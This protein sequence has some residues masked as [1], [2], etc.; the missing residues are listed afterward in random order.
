MKICIIG[1]EEPVYF[2]PFLRSIIEARPKDII[3]VVIAGNRGAGNHPKTL[4]GK[5]KYIYILWLI[6]EPFGF[7]R[8]IFI[9]IRSLLLR[10]L[11]PIGTRLDRRSIEGISRK[12]HIPLIFTKD[13]NSPETIKKLGK[14][15]PDI[16][17]NQSEMLLKDELLKI[18]RLGV[19]NRHASLL[20]N[21]RGR[22]A[23]FWSHAKEPPEYGVTIHF[24]DKEIDSGP[25]ILQRKLDIDPRLSYSKVLDALFKESP[26]LMLEAI[27]RI[28]DP[29]FAPLQNKYEGSRPHLF[30]TLEEARTYRETLK[31]RRES[32]R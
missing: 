27:D 2:S 26:P 3:S 25:I 24:V 29:G 4:V 19:I 6:M 12:H 11:G 17:I 15:L 13:P 28:S 1:Q 10:F 14:M 20:P 16:V 9:R 30:P 8:N 18:P 5:I 7:L 32:S 22:L 21:F 23:S 31:K